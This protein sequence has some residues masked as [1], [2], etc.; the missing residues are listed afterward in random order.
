M[1]NNNKQKQFCRTQ[2][3]IAHHRCGLNIYY[4]RAMEY[5]M[6]SMRPPARS[7]LGRIAAVATNAPKTAARCLKRF[8]KASSLDNLG[9]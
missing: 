2:I 9:P 4:L 8:H 7:T 3:I 1:Q 5:V 6:G